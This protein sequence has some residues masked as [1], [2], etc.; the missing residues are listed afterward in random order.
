MTKIDNIYIENGLMAKISEL[1][2]Q[3][4]IGKKYAI[5][6]DSKVKKI[7]G[8]ALHKSLIKNG[9]E[10]ELFD[11]KEGEKSKTLTTVEK[12]ADQ[13]VEKNFDRKDAIIALGGGVVG[14]LAGFLAAIYM[15]GINCIQI[16]TTLLAMVD[17]AIGGKTGVDLNSGKNLIGTITQPKAIFIDPGYLKTLPQN[18]IINGMAEVIKYGVIKD[19]SLFKFI[20]ENLEKIF[21]Q[22]EKTLLYIIEKSVKIKTDVVKKDEKENGLR[23]ILNYGHTYGHALEKLS[24]YTLLHGYAISIGMVIVNKIAVEKKLLSIKDSDRIKNLLK[25]TGLPVVTMQK[26]STKDLM[27]DKKRIGGELNLILATKIGSVKIVKEKI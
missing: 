3:L 19:P 20:E 7:W 8:T 22:D 12:L 27:S 9:I 2:K 6:T 23:M 11:F 13:L 24:K 16:P 5:I 1:I 21:K 14:D 18:Q 26:V 25:K 17:S 10:A 4:N 15:R